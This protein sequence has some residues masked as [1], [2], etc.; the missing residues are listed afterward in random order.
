MNNEK[1]DPSETIVLGK[2]LICKKSVIFEDNFREETVDERKWL[3]EEY[4]AINKEEVC[5][6]HIF[7]LIN[8]KIIFRILNF[9]HIKKTDVAL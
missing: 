4:I 2:P 1:C 5:I 9:C 3:V 6:N 7:F 8:S